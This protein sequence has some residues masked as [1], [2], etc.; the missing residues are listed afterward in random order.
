MN[1]KP[2]EYKGLKDAKDR[3]AK[4]LA[5][6]IKTA[7]KDHEEYIEEKI[8][9]RLRDVFKYKGYLG[10]IDEQVCIIQQMKDQI[11]N[12]ESKVKN[13]NVFHFNGLQMTKEHLVLQYNSAVHMLQQNLS[14]VQFMRDMIMKQ[15]ELTEEDIEKLLKLR[16]SELKKK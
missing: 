13:D 11:D 12:Y 6:D 2:E 15:Y 8:R 10:Q 3:I 9:A 4:P 16:L 14:E 1:N 5:V 7:K